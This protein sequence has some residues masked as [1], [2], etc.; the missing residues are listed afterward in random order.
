M[1]KLTKSKVAVIAWNTSVQFYSSRST[2]IVLV[3]VVFFIKVT[4]SIW[5]TT[6]SYKKY[7]RTQSYWTYMS[8]YKVHKV[9]QPELIA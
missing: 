8:L 6:H 3:F 1:L 7:S 9:D 4:C 5:Y 2:V